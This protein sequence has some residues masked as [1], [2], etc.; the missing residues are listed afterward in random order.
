MC[1]KR[2]FILFLLFLLYGCD[3][4]ISKYEFSLFSMNTIL[5]VTVYQE[6]INK[7]KIKTE[8]SNIITKIEETYSISK[9]NSIPNV[10]KKTNQIHID[11]E[12]FY[13]LEKA[14]Y[15]YKISEK[16]FDIT[17][18]K[19]VKTWGF[20]NEEYNLP[21]IEEIKKA[22]K[23]IGFK[24][25]SYNKNELILKKHVWLD[26][27]GI[28]KGYA[29]EKIVEYL[30]SRGIKAGIVNLGGNL[31]VFGKKPDGKPWV[32]GIKHPRQ[33]NE[34]YKLVE[35]LPDEAIATSGDYER[36]FITNDTR[37]HHILDPE[38]GYPL[39]NEVMAV[40]V[41]STNAMDCDAYSTTMFLI[42]EKKGLILAK[43][44]NIKV[45]FLLKNKEE[46]IEKSN[47]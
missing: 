32:I 20:Y 47:F 4:S 46:I 34:L 41:I 22:K 12:T 10:L 16:K 28:V 25:L 5:T 29:V 33:P 38:S 35:L 17:I 7:E 19:L 37:Y 23:T 14:N 21:T 24:N 15:F 18:G 3:N 6:K 36:F 9:P 44:E 45:L 2:H 8:V 31:K 26:F 13:I 42:G 27:G 11:V 1:Y 43:K 40:S 39:N 30:K